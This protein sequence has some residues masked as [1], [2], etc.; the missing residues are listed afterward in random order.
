V[1]NTPSG[2]DLGR[3]ILY[4]QFLRVREDV[5]ARLL[6]AGSAARALPIVAG[7][8]AAA[9]GAYGILFHEVPLGWLFVVFALAASI[10]VAGFFACVELTTVV[11]DV[12]TL[13]DLERRLGVPPD[14]GYFVRDLAGHHVGRREPRLIEIWNKEV[15]GIKLRNVWVR[16]AALM[17]LWAAA[18]TAAIG[19][20]A[21]LVFSAPEL[22]LVPIAAGIVVFLALTGVVKVSLGSFPSNV[23]GILRD[24]DGWFSKAGIRESPEPD[25]V[26]SKVGSGDR[27][28]IVSPNAG[29]ITASQGEGMRQLSA[30]SQSSAWVRTLAVPLVLTA[31]AAALST[32]ALWS[33]LQQLTQGAQY[34]LVQ[35]LVEVSL[36][37]AVDLA[38]ITLAAI[39][40]MVLIVVPVQL[41]ATRSRDQPVFPREKLLGLLAPI[42]PAVP[43]LVFAVIMREV[44]GAASFN[45]VYLYL[46][47]ALPTLFALFWAMFAEVVLLATGMLVVWRTL[48][49]PRED[50]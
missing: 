48:T 44:A 43:S 34:A 29:A 30:S 4:A 39:V 20:A 15:L 27:Q 17:P 10:L 12:V 26:P 21:L 13:A 32:V 36:G 3:Q 37:T 50:L 47:T 24:P 22:L 45:W 42:V 19:D 28:G 7:V 16:T 31:V 25:S 5:E 23:L 11:F 46:N 40:G 2:A 41:S 1:T 33:D 49:G 18:V 14:S 35:P 9:I 38:S 6:R 8:D